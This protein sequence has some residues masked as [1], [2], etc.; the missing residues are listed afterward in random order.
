MPRKKTKTNM[1]TTAQTSSRTSKVRPQTH[2]SPKREATKIRPRGLTG[3]NDLVASQEISGIVKSVLERGGYVTRD[4]VLR[5]LAT[6]VTTVRSMGAPRGQGREGVV[7]DTA[8]RTLPDYAK[9][10][11]TNAGPNCLSDELLEVLHEE[12]GAALDEVAGLA[13]GDGARTPTT[14]PQPGRKGK[15]TQEER[16]IKAVEYQRLYRARMKHKKETRLSKEAKPLQPS[17]GT[18]SVRVTDPRTPQTLI[19]DS[20]ANQRPQTKS[21]I[22][23]AKGNE[24]GKT[25]PNGNDKPSKASRAIIA[26]TT[27]PIAS[28]ANISLDV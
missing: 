24:K 13:I 19:V 26:A 21:T 28:V 22:V 18:I 9:P 7:P 17:P 5:L 6:A 14:S 27:A 1:N 12:V 20:R 10:T 11:S 23:S 4:D 2:Q 16:R 25:L 15:L 3:P 8:S